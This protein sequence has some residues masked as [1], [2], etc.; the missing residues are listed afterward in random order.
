MTRFAKRFLTVSMFLG[1]LFALIIPFAARAQTN[2][3]PTEQQLRTH[4]FERMDARLRANRKRV[5]GWQS[6]YVTQKGTTVY[7]FVR[8]G[9]V[10]SMAIG[11]SRMRKSLVMYAPYGDRSGANVGTVGAGVGAGGGVLERPDRGTAEA[12]NNG[13]GPTRDQ[14]MAKY[15]E[16]Y[17]KHWNNPTASS[18]WAGL[19]TITNA[20]NLDLDAIEEQIDEYKAKMDE[21]LGDACA[22]M[23][24]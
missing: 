16:C 23:L 15:W 9:R 3:Q 5:H 7:G 6:V 24:Q 1:I 2:Q 10:V 19:K 8:S 4:F 20:I 12:P 22:K 21:C 11:D 17:W 14:C 13:D 18:I